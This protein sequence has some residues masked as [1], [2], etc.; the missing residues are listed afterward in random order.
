MRHSL[1]LWNW[2]LFVYYFLLPL[3]EIRK[4]TKWISRMHF[5]MVIYLRKSTWSFLLIFSLVIMERSVD[6]GSPYMASKRTHLLVCQTH[7]HWKIVV[8]GNLIL[9]THYSLI[10]THTFFFLCLSMIL[11]LQLIQMLF[12][13]LRLISNHAFTWKIWRHLKYFLRIEVA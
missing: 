4:F 8:F 12:S 1:L 7:L 2:S 13:V 10:L 9:I 5:Y 6:F 3:P 11:L